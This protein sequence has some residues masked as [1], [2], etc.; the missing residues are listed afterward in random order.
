M[1]KHGV[2]DVARSTGLNRESI[3]KINGK[4]KPRWETIFKLMKALNLP[5]T[6]KSI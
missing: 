5:L 4:I 2:S 6:M 1:K 3:Y